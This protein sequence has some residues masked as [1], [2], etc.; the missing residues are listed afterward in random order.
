MV[1]KTVQKLD[2]L[3]NV[4]NEYDSIKFA[5]E[6]ESLTRIQIKNSIIN[7]SK[8]GNY[9]WKFKALEDYEDEIWIDH[10]LL[11]IKCSS[12][13]RIEFLNGHRSYGAMKSSGYRNIGIQGKTYYVS[14]LI[15]ETFIENPENKRT[16]DHID[17]N[18]SNNKIENLR[19]FTY[20]EQNYNQIRRPYP[21]NR[22]KKTHQIDFIISLKRSSNTYDQNK[23]FTFCSLY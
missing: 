8:L 4:V 16:V 12:L 14:R 1:K 18:R 3:L 13:G 6:S 21:K 2:D 19:W 17:R 15:A 23:I 10:P 9:F 11:D 7:N 5:A 22:K 20:S